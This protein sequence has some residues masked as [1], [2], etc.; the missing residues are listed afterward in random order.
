MKSR[1]VFL[2]PT[3]TLIDMPFSLSL[4][5]ITMH[6]IPVMYDAILMF[7]RQKMAKKIYYSNSVGSSPIADSYKVGTNL[8]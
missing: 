2:R 8:E 4:V 7:G 5:H 3:L 1:W 6:I